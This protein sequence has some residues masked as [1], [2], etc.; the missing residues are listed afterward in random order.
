MCRARAAV[1]ILLVSLCAPSG[2]C[3]DPPE[4]EMQQAQGAIDAA[5]AAGGDQYASQ[6]FTAAVDALT[7]AHEAANDRDYRQALNFAL[8]ARERAQ[9][10]LKE[11]ADN[12]AAA[13][14]NAER[15]LAGANAT[16]G[17]AQKRLAE[18]EAA[19]VPAKLL[20]DPR[21]QLEATERR[22]QEARAAF[23]RGDFPDATTAAAASSQALSTLVG[24]L[25]SINAPAPRRAR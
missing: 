17:V 6:E 5:R 14:V 25:E 8:D 7:H 13:R 10:A 4:K 15:A 23:D 9:L 21:K 11:A 18:L 16:L 3:G 20:A 2:A 12:K 24:N 22:V 1:L 19:R